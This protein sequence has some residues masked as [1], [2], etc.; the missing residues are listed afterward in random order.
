MNAPRALALGVLACACGSWAG[1]AIESRP[2]EITGAWAPPTPPGAS[3]GAA[4]MR[5][6]S[7]QD[8]RL[9]GAR[10][11]I[12]AS[13]EI[14]HSSVE[15]G[16]SRMRELDSVALLAGEELVLRPGGTHLMLIGLAAPLVQGE[17]F[18]LE[19]QLERAGTIGIRVAVLESTGDH[20]HH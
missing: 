17:T 18:P 2:A 19:L 4:Y 5:V 20:A 15:G 13:V 14:H 16:T 7:T 6:S 12:A 11:P 3:V 8:D 9:L 1:C 10:S